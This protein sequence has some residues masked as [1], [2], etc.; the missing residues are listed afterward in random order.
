MEIRN[1]LTVDSLAIAITTA[2]QDQSIRDRATILVKRY[3]EK[4]V[5]QQQCKL[6]KKQFS[7]DICKF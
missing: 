1:E 6:L 3:A 5:L 7:K 4:M 2:L